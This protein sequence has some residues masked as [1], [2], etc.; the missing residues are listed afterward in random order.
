LVRSVTRNESG[1]VKAPQVSQS[2]IGNCTSQ[3]EAATMTTIATI[4][5]TRLLRARASALWLSGGRA[6]A[7]RLSWVGSQA[8]A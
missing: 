2:L 5:G 6:T 3:F 4:A 7:I 8:A 1:Y